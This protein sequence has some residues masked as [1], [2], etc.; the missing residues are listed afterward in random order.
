MGN[1]LL[2]EMNVVKVSPYLREDRP[3]L[4][5]SEK[6][7]LH[8]RLFPIAIGEFVSNPTVRVAPALIIQVITISASLSI[9]VELRIDGFTAII[10]AIVRKVVIPAII[11]ILRLVFFSFNLKCL[12]FIFKSL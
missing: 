1:A 11:S 8:P 10:Y 4:W 12:L 2:V 6:K 5:L 9:P 3:L 7:L